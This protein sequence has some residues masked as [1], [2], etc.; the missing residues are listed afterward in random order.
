VLLLGVYACGFLF[1]AQTVALQR[2]YL[3][4]D[5]RDGRMSQEEFAQRDGFYE[6]V[7]WIF[8]FGWIPIA[9]LG[10]VLIVWYIRLRAKR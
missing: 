5:L 6:L 8:I 9:V 2:V 4:I 10:L 1:F 3:A 7:Q